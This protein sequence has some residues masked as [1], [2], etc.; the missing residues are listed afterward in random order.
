MGGFKCLALALD[1]FSG[2]HAIQSC[3]LRSLESIEVAV[4]KG[5]EIYHE[6]H[7]YDVELLAWPQ[8]TRSLVDK[9]FAVK[10]SRL[11]GTLLAEKSGHAV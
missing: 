1:R 5:M 10:G 4:R 3:V 6:L 2:N 9:Y 8:N 7:C 11:A